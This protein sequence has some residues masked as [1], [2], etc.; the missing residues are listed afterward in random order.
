[1]N[2][3]EPLLDV[4]VVLVVFVELFSVLSSLFWVLLPSSGLG[5]CS[6]SPFPGWLFLLSSDSS[7]PCSPS[8]SSS[9]WSFP[10][11]PS[12]SSWL[13]SS[14][15]FGSV[16]L[17]LSCVSLFWDRLGALLPVWLWAPVDG[18]SS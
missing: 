1:M 12:S 6:E 8:S 5:S 18:S 17:R 9:S 3:K 7:C 16:L 4:S 15:P 13:F 2:K 11:S 10:C 14:V